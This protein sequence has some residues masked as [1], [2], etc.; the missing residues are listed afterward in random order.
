MNSALNLKMEL[1]M[2]IVYKKRFWWGGGARGEEGAVN[3]K[4][5]SEENT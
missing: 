3:E 5:S 1:V 2:R 4:A